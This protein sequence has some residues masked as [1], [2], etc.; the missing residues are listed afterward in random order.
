MYENYTAEQIRNTLLP[1]KVNTVFTQG[2]YEIG[3]LKLITDGTNTL[4]RNEQGVILNVSKNVSITANTATAAENTF[5]N[6]ITI[7][8]IDNVTTNSVSVT[9]SGMVNNYNKMYFILDKRNA[10]SILTFNTANAVNVSGYT[11]GN[12]IINGTKSIKVVRP[13]LQIDGELINNGTIEL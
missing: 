3:I 4:Y 2:E 1:K 12:V 8:L 9:V 10:N 5:E 13:G 7:K 11:A 6:A